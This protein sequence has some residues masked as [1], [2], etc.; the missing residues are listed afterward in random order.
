MLVAKARR[1]NITAI[2]YD[3]LAACNSLFN[4]KIAP[5]IY[6]AI[7]KEPEHAEASQVFLDRDKSE[8]HLF[9]KDLMFLPHW[10]QRL[11]L[12]KE[13]L[14]PDRQYLIQQSKTNSTIIAL[15]QRLFSGIRK[16]LSG[17]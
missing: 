12:I 8:M 14:V 15:C 13:H 7:K 17:N 4:T 1:K 10:S 11:T 16:K 5:G 9:W 3:G 6:H 2:V